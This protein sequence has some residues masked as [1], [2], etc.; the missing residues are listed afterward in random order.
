MTKKTSIAQE[1][2]KS[3]AA[4][5][6]VEDLKEAE[7]NR[8]IQLAI[9]SAPSKPLL[10]DTERKLAALIKQGE[11]VALE[12]ADLE[13]DLRSGKE[14][15]QTAAQTLLV[16]GTMPEEGRAAESLK[17]AYRRREVIT[18]A[19][20]L[21]RRMVRELALRMSG[22]VNNGLK[23]SRQV[24]VS[25][26]AAALREL[27]AAVTEDGLFWACIRK[28]GVERS[29]IDDIDFPPVSTSCSFDKTWLQARLEQGY[30]I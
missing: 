6:A 25:R 5:K 17:D 9:T 19:I 28:S 20:M 26:M 1:L 14:T 27:R 30:H 10:D 23:E 7:V 22:E 2:R 16:S 12:I 21:A 4:V 8:L 29:R 3:E 15:P 11:T 13:K 24:I 18:E